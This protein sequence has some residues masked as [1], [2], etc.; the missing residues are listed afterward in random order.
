MC[1]VVSVLKSDNANGE[2]GF[3]GPCQLEVEGAE[4]SKILC[5]VRRSRGDADTVTLMWQILHNMP[6]GPQQ[7]AVDDFINATGE[8]VF[9]PGERDKV[10]YVDTYLTVIVSGII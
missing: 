9:S 3:S 4:Y 6:S 10:C 1:I 5:P 2:F 8:F 7:L